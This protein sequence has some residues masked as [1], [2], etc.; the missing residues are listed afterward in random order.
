MS[1]LKFGFH[2]FLNAQPLLLPLL[3]MAKSLDCEICID[4]PSNLAGKLGLGELDLA[5]IPSVE[6]LRKA[7]IYKIL[8]GATIASCG[9][10]DTVLFIT[11]KNLEDIQTIG[12]DNRSKTSVALF[13]ILFG[14]KLDSNVKTFVEDPGPEE[15]LKKY[16]AALI[17]GDPAF[18]AGSQFS[19]LKIYD[20]SH[21]WFRQTGK[22]FVHAVIA[23][24]PEIE[25]PD[26]LIDAFQKIKVEGKKRIPE[27]AKFHSTILDI[28]EGVA[29]NYLTHKIIYDLDEKALDGLKTFHSLCFE[30][31]LV[32]DKF[33]LQFQQ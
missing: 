16:D 33:S 12:L 19:D 32:E 10:V 3:E 30:K 13:K 8:P 14:D 27:I 5:M 7:D 21:E 6:Y 9:K 22:P 20:L 25:L 28:N 15:A 2:N 23:V 17:I 31:G 1:K 4:S 24:R 18:K 26:G 29:E 11:H